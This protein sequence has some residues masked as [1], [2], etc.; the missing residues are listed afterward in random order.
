MICMIHDMRYVTYTIYLPLVSVIYRRP[1]STLHT[2]HDAHFLIDGWYRSWHLNLS[3][4][5]QCEMR[6]YENEQKSLPSRNQRVLRKGVS[7]CIDLS[8]L[9]CIEKVCVIVY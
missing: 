9:L 1:V 6:L 3:L 7:V 5:Q 8:V 2:A 4:Y